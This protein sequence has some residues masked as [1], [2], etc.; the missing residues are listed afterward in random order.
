MSVA[1]CFLKNAHLCCALSIYVLGSWSCWVSRP[2]TCRLSSTD[3]QG[4][5]GPHEKIRRGDFSFRPEGWAGS[6]VQALLLCP[7][8]RSYIC[9]YQDQWQ[10]ASE[11]VRVSREKREPQAQRRFAQ[12]HLQ[13]LDWHRSLRIGGDLGHGR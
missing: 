1:Y 6:P 13:V 2:L 9:K 10:A 4:L 3:A 12:S 8:L 11:D 5:L 7:N